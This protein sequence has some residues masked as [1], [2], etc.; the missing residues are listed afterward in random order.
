MWGVCMIGEILE[1]RRLLKYQKLSS[2][3]ILELQNRKLHTVIRHAYE[4]VPY[5]HLLFSSTGLTPEDIRTTDDLKYL[6]ITTKD[7]LRAAGLDKVT[8]KEINLSSCITTNTSGATGKPFI[9]YLTQDEERTRRLVQF[10]ALLSMG[11]KPRDRFVVLGSEEPHKTRLHQHLGLYQ[12]AKIS[13]FLPVEDQIQCLQSIQPTVLWIYPT[14]LRALLHK[15]D[16]RLSK[17]IRPR[18]L[19]TVGE[20][21]DE[22]MRERILADLNIELFSLYGA[23]EARI[24]AGECRTHEGLHVNADHVILEILNGHKTAELGSSGTAI[25]TTLNVFTMPFIRYHL[26]DICTFIDKR[27][28]CGSS[29]PL[30]SP[31]QGRELDMVRLPSGRV[32]SPLPFQS[33]LQNISNIDQFRIIQKSYDQFT[34]QLVFKEIPKQE[35]LERIRLQCLNYLGEP[36]SFDIYVVNFIKDENSKFK[37]FISMLD[38]TDL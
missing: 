14:V 32:L 35:L 6:P 7:D 1:L 38:K 33:I 29:F 28:S 3:A 2:D 19:I 21:F 25:L 4:N 30:I 8:S 26:G 36:V 16:Y 10:R 22:V 23:T 31:P 15:I 17:F 11:L 24:I 13:R 27:C 34:F 37:T 5:Y 18:I 9:I 20:V 12:S